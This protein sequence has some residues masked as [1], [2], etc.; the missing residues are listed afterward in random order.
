MAEEP[1]KPRSGPQILRIEEGEVD[2]KDALKHAMS[3][4]KPKDGDQ[5][6]KDAKD[7]PD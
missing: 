7:G 1:A 4:D 6:S 5:P 3:K 2:W